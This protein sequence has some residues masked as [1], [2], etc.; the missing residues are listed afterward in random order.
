VT[1]APVELPGATG[2]EFTVSAVL[3]LA[4]LAAGPGAGLVLAVGP[5]GH[6]AGVRLRPAP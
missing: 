3:Q 4:G 5:H 6:L 2:Q 1:L